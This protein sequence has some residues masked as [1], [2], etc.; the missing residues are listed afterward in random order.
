MPYPMVVFADTNVDSVTENVSKVTREKF[1]FPKVLNFNC[2]G[3][4]VKQPKCVHRD[5]T[6][7]SLSLSLLVGCAELVWPDVG[8]KSIPN[9]SKSCL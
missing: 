3:L 6:L 8:V 4:F 2:P 7:Q 5:C 1:Q 9:V